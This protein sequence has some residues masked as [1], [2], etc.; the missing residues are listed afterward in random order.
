M[1]EPLTLY[2]L[3]ILYMLEHVTFPLSNTQ[4]TDFILEQGYTNYFTLQQ[5]INELLD[6]ELI[7]VKTVRNTSLYRITE[8]GQK[9]LD[10]MLGKLPNAIRKD[11]DRY[12]KENHLK[13]LNEISVSADYYKNTNDGFSVHCVVREG[14]GELIE[15]TLAVPDPKQANR[16]CSRW[17]Q[18]CQKIYQLIMEE[19]S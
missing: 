8:A 5:T 1:A 18:K 6:T 9:T 19:L 15:L 4:L 16:M 14:K 10:Y 3:I 17:E 7:H 13:L 12:L 11:I 2:K